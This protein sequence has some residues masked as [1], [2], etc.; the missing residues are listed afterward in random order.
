MKCTSSTR[1][2]SELGEMFYRSQLQRKAFVRTVYSFYV[3][4]H[5]VLSGV[6]GNKCDD[7]LTE[8]LWPVVCTEYMSRV[9]EGN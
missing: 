2:R 1:T 9:I 8:Q 7:I 6:T 3:D 4:V 5:T